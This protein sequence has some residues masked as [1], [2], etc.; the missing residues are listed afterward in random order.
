[1]TAVLY[2]RERALL[3]Y[4]IQFQEGNGYSP[5]LRE[6]AKAM[7]RRS[8]ATIHNLIR[9]LVD[10]GYIQK[11]DGNNRTL[12]ILQ[13]D[14]LGVILGNVARAVGPTISL[15]LMGYIAAGSPLEPHSDP[16]ATLEIAS[17]MIAGKKTSYALQVKGNSMIEDGI[18]DGDY[19]VI[20]K[21]DIADN[22]DIVV[23]LVNDNLATLKRFLKEDGRIVLMP[24]NRDME[25]IYPTELKIQGKVVGLIRRFS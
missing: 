9:S 15:P 7:D 19:V 8:P 16:E 1:M 4:I 25:P 24:A 14:K 17:T 18:L 6:M 20:E 13:K 11:V 12:K 23:A 2:R 10:K 3:Q 22:G 5:T 21:S